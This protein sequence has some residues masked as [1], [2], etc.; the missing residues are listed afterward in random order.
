MIRLPKFKTNET[1]VSVIKSRLKK[2]V[3]GTQAINKR[4]ISS[5]SI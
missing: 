3:H 5:V 4:H 1:T 2:R